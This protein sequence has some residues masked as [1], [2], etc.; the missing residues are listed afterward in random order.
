LGAQWREVVEAHNRL[1]RDAV[2]SAGGVDLRTEGDAVFAVFESA[3]AAAAAAA[4]AQRELAGRDWPRPIRVRMGLHT[5]EGILGGDDYV[6]LDVHR[7]A[8]IAA[9]GHS[10]Q[11][12]VSSATYELVRASL[13]DGLGV[14]D[15]GS[16]R[17]KDLARTERIYQLTIEGGPVAFPP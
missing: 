11:V 14:R 3:P 12:L 5:G 13:P 4:A 17:L 1:L 10:G 16:H 7:A 6:G 15:L 8:R 2:R 9:A